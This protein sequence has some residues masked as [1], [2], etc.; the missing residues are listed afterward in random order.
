MTAIIFI[1]LATLAAVQ[2]APSSN[3]DV[4]AVIP[5]QR[6]MPLIEGAPEYPEARIT[7]GNT[8]TRGQFPHQAALYLDGSSF[9]GGSLISTTFILTA[10]HC[11]QGISRFTV[12]LGAQSL[13]A[14]ESGRVTVT[15]TSKI[16]HSGYSSSTLN[17][18]IALV[19]LPSAVALSNYIKLVNLPSYSQA[20]NTFAGQSVRVSGWGKVSDAST[21]VSNTLNY[22]DLSVV[23]NAV[24]RNSYGNIIVSST[25]CA[26]GSGGR[27]TCNGDSGGPLVIVSGSSYLQIG[28]VSFVSSRG[29]TSG[30]PSGYARVT[31]YLSWISSN[32]GISIS[33]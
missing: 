7:N 27:S 4:T 26:Q 11:A 16:V 1:A 5:M 13:S 10:A 15:T 25:I 29:C 2:A 23:T 17:N 33:K 3:V 6:T 19:R 12:Y 24:C 28:V 32:A 22:V 20:S 14:S 9:C 31:S 30:A 18:D 8:A 21:S